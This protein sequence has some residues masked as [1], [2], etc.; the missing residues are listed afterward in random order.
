MAKRNVQN[1]VDDIGQRRNMFWLIIRPLKRCAL[2]MMKKKISE[3]SAGFQDI[4]GL[5][6]V[7][8]SFH[9]KSLEFSD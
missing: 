3:I 7:F 2:P 5:D 9:F 4:V 1:P 8:C 6:Y